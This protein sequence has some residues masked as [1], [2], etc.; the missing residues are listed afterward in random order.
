M[1]AIDSNSSRKNVVVLVLDSLRKDR[2]STYN[3]GIE[4]TSNLEELGE[5]SLVFQN[6]VSQAPWTLPS[7]ASIFTGHYP[8][9][10][11]A[12]QINPNLDTSEETLVDVFNDEEYHTA[13]ITS[14]VWITPQTGMAEGFDHVDNFLTDTDNIIVEKILDVSRKIYGRLESSL[15]KKVERKLDYFMKMMEIDPCRS[16]KTVEE[17][18]KY[19]EDR[20]GEEENFF[21][22]ANLMEPHEPYMPPKKY[23]NKHG[24]EDT[25]SIPERQTD[26]FEKNLDFEELE[27]VYD[28]SIDYT[29]DLVGEILD[30]IRNNGLDED[31]VLFVISDHGQ[32]LGENG[33]FGHQFTVTEDIINTVMMINSPEEDKNTEERLLE[34][35]GLRELVPYYAGLRDKPDNVFSERVRGG[36]EFPEQFDGSIPSHKRNQYFRKYRYVKT[37]RRKTVKSVKENGDQEYTTTDLESGKEIETTGDMK[38]EVDR[39]DDVESEKG[40]VEEEIKGR[41]E[42]LGYT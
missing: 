14:N 12:T 8:W 19:F 20:S 29:D 41:L 34:L 25:S 23:M 39:I 1:G 27:K 32:A 10:H 21:L 3:D 5:N 18:K 40:D 31:T 35:R 16:E 11:G 33:L 24:V 28:A 13:A 26:M 30:S 42:E 9:R 36:Y 7:T 6:A 37:Q 2:I 38:T 15:R 17:V 4:F 22:F